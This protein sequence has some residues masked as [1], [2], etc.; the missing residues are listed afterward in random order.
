MTQ[1][2]DNDAISD[3]PLI[4]F[5]FVIF[6]KITETF[7]LREILQIKKLGMHVEIFSLIRPKAGG[8][9]HPEAEILKQK[10]HYSRWFFSR[11][12]WASN[13]FFLI[14]NPLRYLFLLAR[15]LFGSMKQPVLLAKTFA[16]FP[17]SVHFARLAQKLNVQHIHSAFAA[18]N[19]TSAMIMSEL[20]GI[21]YSVSSDQYDLV[22]ETALHRQKLSKAIFVRTIS[23]FNVNL[24][25]KHFGRDIRS[26]THLIF[27]G[28]DLQKYQPGSAHDDIAKDNQFAILCVAA[29]EEKK[30]HRFL[31]E[32]VYNLKR[33][34]RKVHCT[35]VGDG[36]LH[37]ELI[38][39]IYKLKVSDTVSMLGEQ[40]QQEVLDLLQK[41]D[42]YVL[43]S[44]ITPTKRME[45]IPNVL[46]EAMAC[47]IP[48]VATTISGVPELVED[49]KSGLLVP[50]ENA[51]ALNRAIAFIQDNPEA[52]KNFSGAGR[53]KVEREFN[54][55]KNVDKLWQLLLKAIACGKV[56]T[57]DTK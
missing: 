47:K 27:R 36:P 48:V 53:E 7:V 16:I 57:L 51:D 38:Q 29:L 28:V 3:S 21:T 44:I 40:T 15:L 56:N 5:I 50:P 12:L 45:G 17:K 39:Q 46:M 20:S 23:S 43:P 32:A 9:I 41:S 34:G 11:K 37:N 4:A 8:K 24:I 30:G 49:G 19:A 35:L 10:T 2:G 52:A 26:K 55:E 13:F 1:S 18:H 6:P 33:K 54:T 22:I 42:C 14:R 31:I 25:E